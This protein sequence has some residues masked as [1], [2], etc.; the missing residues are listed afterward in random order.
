VRSRGCGIVANKKTP[1]EVREVCALGVV[2]AGALGANNE[3]ELLR[4]AA[5]SATAATGLGSTVRIPGYRVSRL[6]RFTA[7]QRA[8]VRV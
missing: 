1:R 5:H 7:S 3:G 6:V 2:G 8:A 4:H